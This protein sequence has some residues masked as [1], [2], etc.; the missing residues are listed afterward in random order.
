MTGFKPW[1]NRVG[2]DHFGTSLLTY[3]P[4]AVFRYKIIKGRRILAIIKSADLLQWLC[5]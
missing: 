1:S 5:E 4:V 2:G 3:N